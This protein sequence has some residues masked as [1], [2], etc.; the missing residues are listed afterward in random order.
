MD[1]A[2]AE[3]RSVKWYQPVL[4]FFGSG[5]CWDLD[6]DRGNGSNSESKRRAAPAADT[7]HCG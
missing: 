4:Y 2:S 1:V 3:P 5:V 7:G 6:A